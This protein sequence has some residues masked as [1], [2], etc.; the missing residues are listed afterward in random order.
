[1]KKNKTIKEPKTFKH[2]RLYYQPTIKNNDLFSSRD[3]Y[4]RLRIVYPNGTCE[5]ARG[6]YEY[7]DS[8][9]NRFLEICNF[10]TTKIGYGPACWS[11]TEAGDPLF[12]SGLSA[13]KA[14]R[15]YDKDHHF[16]R[17]IFMGEIK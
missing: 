9:G 14:M 1:M 7:M 17:A 12:S 2:P 10:S 6:D 5:W 11:C 15:R 8:W 4:D 13:L 16:P 3:Y